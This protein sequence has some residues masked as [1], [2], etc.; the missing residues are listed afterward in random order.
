MLNSEEI[1]KDSQRIT[2]IKPF[3]NKCNWE[4]IHFPSQKDD[5]K[6]FQKNNVTIALNIL[7]AK[8]EKIYPAYISKHTSNRAKQV[9]LLMIPN[10]E[11]WHS[12]E[13][14]KLSAL[15]TGTTSKHYADFYFLNCLHSLRAKKKLEPHM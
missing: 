5:W 15:L 4:G 14:K 3:I 1:K 10:A 9:I 6:Q 11:K 7:Y 8:K 13:V 2:K 12:L